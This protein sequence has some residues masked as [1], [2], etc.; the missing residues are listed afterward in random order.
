MA[1]YRDNRRAARPW[2]I[3]IS[4]VDRRTGKKVRYFRNAKLQTADGAR[5]EERKLLVTYTEKG[6]I[7]GPE[8]VVAEQKPVK[9]LT[10]KEAHELYK[11]TLEPTLKPSTS[12]GY[13]KTIE[14]H[15]LP[16]FGD[17]PLSKIDRAAIVTLD[18]ELVR[19]GLSASTRNNIVIPLRTIVGNAIELN[20]YAGRPD[21]P[22]LNKVK[23]KI[24][25]PP[26][27]EHVEAVIIAA[28][29]RSRGLKVALSLAAYAGLRASEVR[30]L[31]WVNVDLE[32]G[33][34]FVREALT[35]GIVV[36]TK[37]GHE[38]AIPLTPLLKEVLAEAEKLPHKPSD[39][40]APARDGRPMSEEGLRSGF[41]RALDRANLPHTRL[42]DLR[43]FFITE[44]F[45]GGAGAPTVQKLAGHLHLTTTQRYAHTNEGLMREAVQI[46][47]KS[48]VRRACES[49]VNGGSKPA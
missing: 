24:F 2:V 19:A 47:S 14:A 7:P 15:L 4:F 25:Q 10:L 1:T 18:Q 30:G 36:D 35:H 8:D 41:R 11:K 38:R 34:L 21:F 6:F 26:S 20:R 49:D 9:E 40:V 46:L 48:R 13:G 39:P 23:S 22:R 16:R 32:N 45:A 42:H 37:S 31:R 12:I 43:H 27:Y 29:P 44:C 17:W 33:L 28:G 5:A 3:D